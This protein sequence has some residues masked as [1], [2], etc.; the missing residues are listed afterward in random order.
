MQTVTNNFKEALEVS[1]IKGSDFDARHF[2]FSIN[3]TKDMAQYINYIEWCN[4]IASASKYAGL[5]EIGFIPLIMPPSF[6]GDMIHVEVLPKLEG[7][8]KYYPMKA[9]SFLGNYYQ[10]DYPDIW[11]HRFDAA[12][13]VSKKPQHIRVKDLLE[14][15]L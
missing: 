11:V 1:T 7:K 2:I 13:F 4:K 12:K 9:R 10:S 5:L 8:L 14:V 3:S 6:F 15:L